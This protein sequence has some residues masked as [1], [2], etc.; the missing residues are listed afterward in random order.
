MKLSRIKCTIVTM[1]F[2]ATVLLLTFS[3]NTYPL[4]AKIP[5]SV[6]VKNDLNKTGQILQSANG[7]Q[8][9]LSE[10]FFT[11]CTSDK[12]QLAKSNFIYP[13]R[14][15]KVFFNRDDEFFSIAIHYAMEGG[16]GKIPHMFWVPYVHDGAVITV[17]NH[18]LSVSASVQYY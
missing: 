5:P 1:G 13:H 17:T 16:R 6:T 3:T 10:I 15:Q 18:H 2:L 11:V 8:I 7:P 12:R 4:P 14:K 9:L